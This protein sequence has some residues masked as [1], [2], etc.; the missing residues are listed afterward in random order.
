MKTWGRIG[1]DN[2]ALILDLTDMRNNCQ[3][4]ALLVQI[5]GLLVQTIFNTWENSPNVV[6]AEVDSKEA[7]I[8]MN[9]LTDFY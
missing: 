7:L 3:D 1:V 4:K 5:L 8:S 6:M 9:M 2:K